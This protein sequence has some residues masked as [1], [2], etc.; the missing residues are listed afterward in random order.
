MLCRIPAWPTLS[1]LSKTFR[2]SRDTLLNIAA[3]SPVLKPALIK[4]LLMQPMC[5]CLRIL[6]HRDPISTIQKPN[7]KEILRLVDLRRMMVKF[8]PLT[9]THNLNYAW[10]KVYWGTRILWAMWHPSKLSWHHIDPDRFRLR[11]D[12]F[13]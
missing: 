7:A 11:Y 4:Q 12:T 6:S 3:F 9:G 5:F 2:V 8:G 10:L 1:A 13:A